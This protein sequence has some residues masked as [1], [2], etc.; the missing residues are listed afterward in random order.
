MRQFFALALIALALVVLTA[1]SAS[2]LPRN[3]KGPIGRRLAQ[4]GSS[5]TTTT[6]SYSTTRSFSS[7]TCSGG[8]CASGAC[9]TGNCAP[10]CANGVCASPSK[11]AAKPA[12]IA[13]PMPMSPKKQ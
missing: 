3:G 10:S 8:S 5:T 4:N 13:K 11:S 2:A 7:G 9:V 1:D 6:K 12:T